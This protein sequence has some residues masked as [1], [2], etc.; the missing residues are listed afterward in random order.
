MVNLQ[1]INEN[2]LGKDS[3]INVIRTCDVIPDVHEIIKS[4]KTADMPT[5]KYKWNDSKVN[6]MLVDSEDNKE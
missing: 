5:Q 4:S 1:F 2:K 6:V 3:I